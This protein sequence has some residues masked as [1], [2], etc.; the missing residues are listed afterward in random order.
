M[1]CLGRTER[2]KHVCLVTCHMQPLQH[3]QIA[4]SGIDIDYLWLPR[5]G[6]ILQQHPLHK[7]I[8]LF[9]MLCCRLKTAAFPGAI[10]LAKP[11][12][13]FQIPMPGCS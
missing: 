11:L 2:C 8:T 6:V 4:S 12:H 5:T 7:L 10:M 1:P 3:A 9:A 13:C